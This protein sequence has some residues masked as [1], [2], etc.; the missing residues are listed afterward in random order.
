MY[1]H[2]FPRH[3]HDV[4]ATEVR[5]RARIESL[6]AQSAAEDSCEWKSIKWIYLIWLNLTFAVVCFTILRHMYL[7]ILHSGPVFF[8][9]LAFSRA[10]VFTISVFSSGTS[11]MEWHLLKY[12]MVVP[13]CCRSSWV[14]NMM[15]RFDTRTC[16]NSCW[17]RRTPEVNAI[18]CMHFF[19]F[20][21]F[22]WNQPSCPPN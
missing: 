10:V 22:F 3:F 12:W 2:T 21:N 18:Q 13:E 6:R 19:S 15:S 17:T 20:S 14:Q 5:S 4:F 8:A 1:C 9:T 16:E 7:T 11:M